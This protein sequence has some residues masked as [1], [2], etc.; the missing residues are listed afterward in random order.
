MVMMLSNSKRQFILGVLLLGIAGCGSDPRPAATTPE[1]P[2]QPTAE[3]ATP[4]TSASPLEP[5]APAVI[6]A[7]GDIWSRLRQ[8]DTHYYVLMR[9]AIAP[10]TGDPAN[11]QL[12]DCATQRNLSEQGREQARRTGEAFRQQN[13]TVQQVLSSEWC[14]CLETAELIDLAPVDRFPALNSFFQDRSKGPER[15]QQLRDFMVENRDDVGVTVLVTHFVTIS[16]IAGSG[17]SSGELVVMQINE[18]NEPE[19]IGQIEPF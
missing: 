2:I 16:G 14:R 19:V 15:L 1:P 5:D 12:D 4:S 13:V 3:T 7:E 10:G 11:F 6:V 17:V 9:H 8:A 18:K